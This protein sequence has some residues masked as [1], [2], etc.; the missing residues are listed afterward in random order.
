MA[1]VK[2][3]RRR[4][5]SSGR[6]AQARRTQQAIL[7][8][9]QR[10]FLDAGYGATTVATIATEAGVSVETVY[11]AFGGKAGL[12]RALY[13]RALRGPGPVSAYERSDAMRARETDPATIM[14]RWGELTT[15]VAAQMTPIRLL[16]RAAAVTDPEIAAL[17]KDGDDERLQRMRHHAQFLAERRYLRQDITT[18][19]ATD[20]LY[21]CSS[22]EIYDV[23]VLQRGWPLPEFA[24]FVGDFM[25]RALLSPTADPA[26]S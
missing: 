19:Q 11:K 26:T 13:D 17:L 4:Y 15:E 20:I 9:A 3:M 22:L 8:T 18:D 1:S 12:V 6:Q 2:G 7:D 25:I 14:R 5:D 16:I 10:Q 23:L 21:T 24:R